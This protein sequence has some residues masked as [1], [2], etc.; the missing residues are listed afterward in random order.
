MFWFFFCRSHLPER[1]KEKKSWSEYK[2]AVSKQL[3][4]THAFN[5][6]CILSTLFWSPQQ[7]ESILHCEALAT[8]KGHTRSYVRHL[9]WIFLRYLWSYS[10][11]FKPLAS[12]GV[13]IAAVQDCVT[14]IGIIRLDLTNFFLDLFVFCTFLHTITSPRV[15]P[16]LTSCCNHEHMSK[17]V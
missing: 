15:L 3:H 13:W 10:V 11:F 4:S 16:S 14:Q 17:V 5:I 7:F 9:Q 2:K 6:F 12:L 1:K 8:F